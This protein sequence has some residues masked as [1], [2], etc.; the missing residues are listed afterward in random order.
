[1]VEI[2]PEG[3]GNT[4]VAADGGT[5]D[6]DHPVK[7]LWLIGLIDRGIQRSLQKQLKPHDLSLPEYSALAALHF[8]PGM[9]SA[10]LARRALV[11]PQ[12]MNEVVARL[13]QREL[14]VRER[15]PEH[16]RILMTEVTAAGRALFEQAALSAAEVE[17]SLL[18][19]IPAE[20]VDALTGVLRK[21]LDR[22]QEA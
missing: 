9:S 1:M 5:I 3:N 7:F 11:T 13:E 10:G 8:N 6:W 4:S 18:E 16:G 17:D 21:I 19:A 15:H 12:S 22:Q 2:S 20:E 14:V